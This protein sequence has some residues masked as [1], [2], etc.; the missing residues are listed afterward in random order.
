VFFERSKGTLFAANR[1]GLWGYYNHEGKQVIPHR[2]KE[3]GFSKSNKGSI[4]TVAGYFVE[5]VTDAK[6]NKEYILDL[7]TGGLY[8]TRDARGLMGDKMIA[9]GELVKQLF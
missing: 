6:D 3:R 1:N 7:Y 8:L 2:F 9:K 4:T 5:Y